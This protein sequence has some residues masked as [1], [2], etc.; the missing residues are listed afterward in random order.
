MERQD[1]GLLSIL[2]DT[3]SF[4][5]YLLYE[6]ARNITEDFLSSALAGNKHIRQCKDLS[7]QSRI[8]IH[9]IK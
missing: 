6:V 8:I 9:S 1:N 2:S 3:Y 7:P 4:N 5:I